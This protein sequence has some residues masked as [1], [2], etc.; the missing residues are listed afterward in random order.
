MT[1]RREG[2]FRG[3]GGLELFYQSWTTSQSR[4]TLVI[5]HGIGEH[6]ECYSKTAAHLAPMGWN[7]YAFDLRGHGRSEGKR[8][9]VESFQHYSNDLGF[10]LKFLKMSGR[11]ESKFALIGH[12]MGGL[13]TLRHLLDTDSSLPQASAAVLSS[14]LLGFSIRIPPV[15]DMAARLMVRLLPSIT[16]FNE[17]DYSD[18]TRDPEFLTGYETDA[19]RHDRISPALYLG[20]HENIAYVHQ[21]AERL[22]LPILVQA[23]GHEKIVSL[24]AIEEFF[25]RI[26]SKQKKLIVYKDSYHEIFNDL[27]RAK[28][29]QDLHDFLS[30]ALGLRS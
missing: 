11:L 22:T 9:F 30:T 12:S 14:P 24:S 29:F 13:I 27:D 6:S 18:L 2:N 5:T 1:E 20:M 17:L 23:A 10:F 25:P 26:G 15:K 16:L 7:I 28:V 21:T 19:L 8:G 4:A 3:E